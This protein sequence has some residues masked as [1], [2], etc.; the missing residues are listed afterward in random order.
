MR[1]AWLSLLIILL[2]PVFLL[3]LIVIHEL[4]HTGLARLLGDPQ[5]DFYL[6]DPGEHSGCMLGCTFYDVTKLTWGANLVVS[7]SGLFAGQTV[8]LAALFLLRVSEC[9]HFLRSIFSALALSCA[10]FDVP[11]QVFQSLTYNLDESAWPTGADLVDLLLLLRIRFDVD[12]LFLKGLLFMVA[13]LYLGGFIWL[14]RRNR[15]EQKT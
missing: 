5:A 11:W 13:A 4:G 1:Q 9:H 6:V 3:A 7:V 12:Q 8:A 15:A 2:V 14:Y 10:F